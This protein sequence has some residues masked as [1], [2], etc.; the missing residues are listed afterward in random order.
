MA[1]QKFEITN[2]ESGTAVL[3]QATPQAAQNRIT[4]NDG[5]IIY[6][7]LN[8]PAE[9]EAVDEALQTFFARTLGV[10][11]G[12]VAVASGKSVEK[13]IVIIMGV[14]PESVETQLTPQV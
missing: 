3:V 11:R 6:V 9:R 14:P 12:K 5:D 13:K 8:A 4:G 2:A 7:E 10:N 1:I